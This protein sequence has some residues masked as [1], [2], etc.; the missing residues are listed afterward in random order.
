MKT[1]IVINARKFKIVYPATIQTKFLLFSQVFCLQMKVHERL[2]VMNSRRDAAPGFAPGDYVYP[3]EHLHTKV[4]V[5]RSAQE[6]IDPWYFK[7]DGLPSRNKWNHSRC[8]KQTKR[9]RGIYHGPRSNKWS[10]FFNGL[11][12][13][14]A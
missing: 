2:E 10:K 12:L 1:V 4:G 13:A 11:D 9:D 6:P 7:N 5:L 8:Y 3:E 14:R